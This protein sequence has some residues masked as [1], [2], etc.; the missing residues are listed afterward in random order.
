M[1]T[2]K[3]NFKTLNQKNFSLTLDPSCVTVEDL[4]CKMEDT[5]GRENL[6]KLIFAGKLLK[7]EKNL[8]DYNLNSKIPVIVMITKSP[9]IKSES[10]KP[11]GKIN[12]L[13]WGIKKLIKFILLETSEKLD[14]E[15]ANF[16]RTRTVT[17]DSGI[18]EDFNSD[19]FVLQ[20]ELTSV[21]EIIKSCDYLNLNRNSPL[22]ESVLDKEE[23]LIN[24]DNYCEEM[25]TDEDF[26]EMLTLYFDQ[27]LAAQFN[28]PQLL[29][30]LEDLQDIYEEPRERNERRDSRMAEVEDESESFTESEEEEREKELEAKVERLLDMGF[31]REDSE[32]ALETAGYNVSAAVEL[33]MPS[34]RPAPSSKPSSGSNPLSFLRD[35]EEFQFLRYQVLHDPNLLQPL[36]IS[37]GQSHPDIMKEINQNKDIFISMLYEQTGAKMHGRH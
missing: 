2:T 10:P 35:I 16:K 29:A 36:L 22:H 25:E 24:I 33:L 9:E 15:S 6:Y 5:F 4:I 13:K 7:E 12:F 28:K 21:I 1:T 11:E 20:S 8:S 31:R 26:K 23:I 27:I 17:E 14:L 30:M 34:N 32:R 19:H 18:E 3:L 37:F